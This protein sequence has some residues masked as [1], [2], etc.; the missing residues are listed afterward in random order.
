MYEGDRV[1]LERSGTL[2][3]RHLRHRAVVKELPRKP[4]GALTVEHA[5][6]HNLQDVTVEF[7]LGVLTVVTG[8]AGSGK[9]TLVHGFVPKVNPDTVLID[10]GPIRGSRRSNPATYTGVLEPVRKLFARVNKVSPSLF[11]A[12]SEGACEECAGLGVIFTDLAFMEGVVTVCQVCHGRRFH[13]D[14]LRHTIRD[15]NIAEVLAMS[16]GEALDFFAGNAAGEKPIR[17]PL[18]RLS[19]VGLGYLGLGQALPTLSGGERQRLKLAMELGTTGQV[20]V[21]DE[22]TTGL[23]PS[24]VDGLVT[25]LNRLVD[26]GSTVIVIEH[27]LDVIAKADWVIDLGPG[28]GR[29]G[30]RV[31]FQGTAAELCSSTESVTGRYLAKATSA[32]PG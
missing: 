23:H 26:G 31:V 10:Q 16:V 1:G 9:S 15:R 22:P 14:V 13:E 30:G 21:L 29:D 6:R 12:N 7:P 8:V 5:T 11:S 19:D 20:Y 18:Q 25:L 3:G 28:P 27:N 17:E 24:D 2:T 4:S 32:C